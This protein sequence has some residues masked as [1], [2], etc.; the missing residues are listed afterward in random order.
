M[1]AK[2]QTTIGTYKY[3]VNHGEATVIHFSSIANYL[4]KGGK[5]LHMEQNLLIIAHL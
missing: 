3:P 2:D 5:L 1:T 4:D